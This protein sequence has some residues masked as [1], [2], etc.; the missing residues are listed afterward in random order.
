MN[1]EPE[2]ILSL[3]TFVDEETGLYG[4][5]LYVYGLKDQQMADAAVAYLRKTF[6]GG[7]VTRQ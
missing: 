4:V 2:M 7:E 5:E 3:R 6:C 1:T